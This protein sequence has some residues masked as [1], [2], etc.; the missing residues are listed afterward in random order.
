MGI[1]K[2]FPRTFKRLSY[3]AEA[4]VKANKTAAPS[5]A[6]VI[7]LSYG[8][9]AIYTRADLKGQVEITLFLKNEA[10]QTV[11]ETLWGNVVWKREMGSLNAIGLEFGNLNPK[12]HSITMSLMEQLL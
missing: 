3:I 2:K 9:A 7:N 5:E 6:H 8:G 11:A 10:G 4:L 1:P 12:D